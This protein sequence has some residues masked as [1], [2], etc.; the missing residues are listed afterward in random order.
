[1]TAMGGTRAVVRYIEAGS[2]AACAECGAQVQFRARIKVQQVICN[3]YVEG[4]WHRVEH[5]HRDCY[6]AAGQ[7]H[8]PADDSQPVRPKTRA[9]AAAAAAVVA[10]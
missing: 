6:E 1:M 3:V 5:Y 4:R 7:P 2:S 9:V 10:A 8:G